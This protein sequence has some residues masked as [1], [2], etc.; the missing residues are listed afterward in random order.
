MMKQKLQ[1]DI[2]SKKKPTDMVLSGVYT[3]DNQQ[4]IRN[5]LQSKDE[6]R[7][8]RKSN[9]END[10]IIKELEEYVKDKKN[11][12]KYLDDISDFETMS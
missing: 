11:T 3:P 8:S 5:K 9:Q 4:N 10:D 7:Y 12:G 1:N 6:A 2:Q